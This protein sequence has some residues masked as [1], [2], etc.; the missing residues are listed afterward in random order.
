MNRH[1]H[2]DI[3]KIRISGLA[4][5]HHE[6]HFS[7]NAQEIGLSGR[8]QSPVGIEATVD[9]TARQIFLTASVRASGRF[10]CD[11][12]LG[13]FDRELTAKYRT[14]YVYDELDGMSA[15]GN[16]VQVIAPDT[17][18]IDLAEDVRQTIELAV[19]LKLLCAEEC[20]GL[21]RKCGKNLNLGQCGCTEDE[22][23]IRWAP[24]RDQ[25]RN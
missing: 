17:D 24:L 2:A 21:C 13:E 23:D 15:P 19:P 7:A 8:F 22:V 12:C 1:Q 14:L 9:K 5:G 25:L 10:E 16:E 4:D 20:K 6:Y 18:Y 3:V 11:R